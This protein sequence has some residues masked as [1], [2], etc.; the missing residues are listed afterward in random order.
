MLQ[1]QQQ[2]T[3]H[4]LPTVRRVSNFKKVHFHVQFS[5]FLAFSILALSSCFEFRFNPVVVPSS[6]D[7]LNLLDDQGQF[8]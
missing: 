6:D 7:A 5:L 2:S 8:S 1:Q 4:F 3:T